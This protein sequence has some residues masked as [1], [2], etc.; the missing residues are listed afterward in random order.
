[1]LAQLAPDLMA[2][3]PM[4]ADEADEEIL[5][6]EMSFEGTLLTRLRVR[7]P[8]YARWMKERPNREPGR[9]LKLLQYVQWQ[10]GGGGRPWVLKTPGHVG[11][12]V[13]L[14]EVFPTATV[15]HCHRDLAVAVPSFVRLAG[16]LRAM[17]TDALNRPGPARRE[18]ADEVLD[19]WSDMLAANLRQRPLLTDKNILDVSFRDIVD[20]PLSVIR[21]VYKIGDRTLSLEAEGRM[22]AWARDNP[23]GKY[24]KFSYSLEDYG[25]TEA[26]AWAP[27]AEYRARFAALL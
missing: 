22:L 9:L 23:A 21:E 3:H 15:V 18:L 19:I 10:T 17:S 13:G 24:G 2:A 14:Y 6:L 1:M 16:S 20:D 7:A 11:N 4:V 25:L 27:F 5:A 12:L 26:D 8:S